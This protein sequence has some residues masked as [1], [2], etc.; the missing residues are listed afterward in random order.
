MDTTL[1]K[2][3]KDKQGLTIKDI[4]AAAKL[5]LRTVEDVFSGKTFNPRV[6]TYFAICEV[7]HIEPNGISLTAA[8]TRL[9]T[10][11]NK[12]PEVSQNAVLDMIESLT[13]QGKKRGAV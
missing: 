2:M 5:P 4:A 12:L 9:L 11:F 10:A 7:L 8:E 1:L 6:D 13:G 3:Q